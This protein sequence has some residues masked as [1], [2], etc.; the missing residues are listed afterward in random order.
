L[1]I[2]Q[3]TISFPFS[4]TNLPEP[5]KEKIKV[6]M[7]VVMQNGLMIQQLQL[8]VAMR[9]KE[10]EEEEKR[11]ES[12]WLKKKEAKEEEEKQ[13]KLKEEEIQTMQSWNEKES[14]EYVENFRGYKG[15]TR[16]RRCGWF[17]HMAHHC[18]REEIEAEREQRERWFAN[19]W[20]PLRCRV[21]ACKEE[22]MVVCSVRREVQQQ[23]KCWGCGEAGHC[24]WTCPRKAA[25]PVQGEAQPKNV[26][27]LVC[28][29]CKEENH[30][31]RNCNSY[32]WWRER[33]VKRK[34][35]QLKEKPIGEERCK[36]HK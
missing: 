32:W 23:V 16:C 15:D 35:R 6:L 34:L 29:E 4:T 7:A 25:R 17:G 14:Q 19:Q 21:M 12:C 5:T 28:G 10:I 30:V 31:A 1:W 20:E 33:E 26:R 3:Y 9:E 2:R 11:E 13:R 8:M 36:G 27:K 22:R 18:R 24:L